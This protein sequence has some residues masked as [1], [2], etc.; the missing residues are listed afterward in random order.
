MSGSGWVQGVRGQA[1]PFVAY[2]RV[3]QHG[4]WKIAQQT[5]P[6]EHLALSP[7]TI[8]ARAHLFDRIN[9]VKEG[10]GRGGVG[11]TIAV[12]IIASTTAVISTTIIV[13][14]VTPH[15]AIVITAC[16]KAC[17]QWAVET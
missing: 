2:G 10:E 9:V 7:S 4:S 12:V 8:K 1:G 17:V 11:T 15:A 3:C 5:I 14:T 16:I 6:T 13:P